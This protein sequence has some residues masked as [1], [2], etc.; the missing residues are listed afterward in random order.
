MTCNDRRVETGES[1]ISFHDINIILESSKLTSPLGKVTTLPFP[2]R[3][4]S[5][6]VIKIIYLKTSINFATIKV[7]IQHRFKGSHQTSNNGPSTFKHRFCYHHSSNF[8][9]QKAVHQPS[10]KSS[11]SVAMAGFLPDITPATNACHHHKRVQ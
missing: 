4:I 9:N 2:S 5:A 6:A 10:V 8:I 7:I 1:I 11:P 3:V